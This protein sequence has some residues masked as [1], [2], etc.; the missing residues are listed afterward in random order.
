MQLVN[1][2]NSKLTIVVT[3]II[4]LFILP[5]GS[6]VLANEDFERKGKIIAESVYYNTITKK[7]EFDSES[8]LSNGLTKNEVSNAKA[9]FES[10]SVTEV[11]NMNNEIGFDESLENQNIEAAPYFLPVIPGILIPIAK[12]LLGTAGAVI[13]YHVITYG[14]IKACKN[15]KGEYWFF[16]DFC[17]TNGWL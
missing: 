15:L 9:F 17:E 6:T 5:F 16:T 2:V 12:Y 4:S 11:E 10:L 7:Y 3:M 8:A 14:I 1:K 13:I